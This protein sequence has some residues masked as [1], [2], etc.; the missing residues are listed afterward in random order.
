[1]SSI[2]QPVKEMAV[3]CVDTLI[4]L[5]EKKPVERRIISARYFCG[6]RNHKIKFERR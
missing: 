2:A 5:I 4:K 6:G 3:T 1:M